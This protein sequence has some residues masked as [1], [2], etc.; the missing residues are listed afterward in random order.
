MPFCSS[1]GAENP[2]EARFCTNCGSRVAAFLTEE[3]LIPPFPLNLG[4]LISETFGL[5][6]RNFWP[7]VIIVLLA[8]I[9]N[10]V[11]LI[12]AA[13]GTLFILLT[14]GSVLL[15]ILAYAATIY[16]VAS[17]YLGH[18]VNVGQCYGRALGSVASLTVAF[19]L[20]GV[21]LLF[22]GF[23][24]LFI[25]GIP[26]FFY[27]LVIWFFFPQ[28]I[29]FERKNVIAAFGRSRELVR[30]SWW[31]AFGIGVVFVL[32]MIAISIAASIPGVAADRFSE[33]LGIILGIVAGIIVTPI[34][35]IGGT[36]VYL[37]LRVRKERY[38]LDAMA[39]ELS[40]TIEM[41]L[42]MRGQSYRRLPKARA[43]RRNFRVQEVLQ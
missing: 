21:T 40:L 5:Y 33:T 6:G 42:E 12:I 13:A 16:G 19:I 37:D 18:R 31:R 10:L 24:S 35:Y 28:A 43:R 20:F 3:A 25:I 8:Q 41:P 36:L 29:M 23:L 26:L 11:G 32:V 27:I 7:F 1:C 9:P 30:G 22:T 38:T 2:T 34:G 14:L 17:L 15:G 4:G 39:S